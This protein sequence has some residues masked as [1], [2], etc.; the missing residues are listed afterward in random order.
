M[1]LR[2][3]DRFALIGLCWL[4]GR[5][6]FPPPTQAC[7]R[8]RVGHRHTGPDIMSDPSL[9]IRPMPDPMLAV[10]TQFIS[11]FSYR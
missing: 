8:L 9:Q 10:W 2:Q 3:H 11:S 6:E 5:S 4:Y 1:R 7:L